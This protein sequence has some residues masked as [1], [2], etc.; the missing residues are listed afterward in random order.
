MIPCSP[1][2]RE[3]ERGE[4]VAKRLRDT[5]PL[6]DSVGL[7][8]DSVSEHE[9]LTA[10]DEVRLARAMEQGRDAQRTLDEGGRSS[11]APICGSSSPSPSGIRIA[12]STSSISCRRAIS[13]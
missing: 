13:G 1:V 6:S 11:S 7:Y 4:R 9:L 3:T 12:A 8:L 5:L 2:H 10:E